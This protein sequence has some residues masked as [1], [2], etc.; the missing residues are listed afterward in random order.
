M[1]P[2][3]CTT[4]NCKVH[5]STPTEPKPVKEIVERALAYV[6]QNKLLPPGSQ[7]PSSTECP[8]K[9]HLAQLT[10]LA[11]SATLVSSA[12]VKPSKCS[13]DDL[14]EKRMVR[15]LVECQE[16]ILKELLQCQQDIMTMKVQQAAASE[17]QSHSPPADNVGGAPNSAAKREEQCPVGLIEAVPVQSVVT[18]QS[19]LAN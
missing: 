19:N 6:Q 1:L 11:Q 10:S 4:A 18:L 17:G 16:T 5:H 15:R 9:E 12:S 8:V 7:A 14:M 2:D 13:T 3:T